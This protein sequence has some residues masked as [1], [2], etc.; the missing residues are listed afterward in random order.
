MS[1]VIQPLVLVRFCVAG[2]VISEVSLKVG[3]AVKVVVDKFQ[4]KVE[5]S[6]STGEEVK[7]L[8][9]LYIVPVESQVDKFAVG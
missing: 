5:N 8:V 6:I 1:V 4:F 7:L 3:A 2:L 9:A